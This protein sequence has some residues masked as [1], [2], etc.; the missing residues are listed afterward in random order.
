MK[1]I[2]VFSIILFFSMVTLAQDI[3]IINGKYYKAEMLYTGVHKEY[4]E[5]GELL[6]TIHI[7]NGDIDGEQEIFFQSGKK[8]ELRSYDEGL[9]DGTW[10]K[11]NEDG[12]K[13][14]EAN[15]RIDLKHGEWKIWD[16]NGVLRYEMYY[17][18]GKK[19]GTWI[20]YDENGEE[21]GRK[22]Y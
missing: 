13:I 18:K 15:Y 7:V 6:S 11:W 20:M 5:T 19:T 10:I 8:K 21:T 22:K 12:I 17:R 14:A 1:K 2:I 9:K 4:Y 16:D 3:E